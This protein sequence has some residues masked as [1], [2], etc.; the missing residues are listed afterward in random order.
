ME[1]IRQQWISWIGVPETPVETGPL[2]CLAKYSF[3]DFDLEMYS[4]PNGHGRSQRVL[5]AFPKEIREPRPAVAVPFYFAEAMLGFDPETGEEFP[6]YSLY[7]MMA[8]LARRG[9]VAA[10]ADAY[11][12]TY[13]PQDRDR[14]DFGRWR[15]AAEALNREHPRWTGIGKL[16]SDTRL[17]IDALAADPRVDAGRIGIAGH[18]L[19]GK[20]A[21]YTGCLDSRIRV[22]LA[23]DFGIRWD[24]TNWQDP[25]YWGRLVPELEAA[26]MDHAQL[27]GL[28]APKPFCLIAGEFD[29]QDSWDMMCRAPGYDPEAG[30]LKIIH[31]GTGHRPPPD[32]LEEGYSFLDRWLKD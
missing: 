7:P 16:V 17:M 14:G 6:R 30:L 25:W 21:F 24:Q 31:H 5:M 1:K 2:V 10:S 11:H 19:G 12:L 4:Q 8:D 26:G 13:T 9:Y 29:N 15:V 20:M 28:A 3:G 27:L 32:V 22:I 18:S 23:S